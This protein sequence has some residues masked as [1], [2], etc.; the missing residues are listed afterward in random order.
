[1]GGKAVDKAS[2]AYNGKT[3][4]QNVNNLT[5][6]SENLSEWTNPGTWVGWGAPFA[7]RA[8]RT[9]LSAGD[10]I[11]KNA[12]KD[13]AKYG[14]SAVAKNPK[15]WYRPYVDQVKNGWQGW[16]DVNLAYKNNAINENINQ[17]YFK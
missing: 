16:K 6:L 7:S 8:S 9:L 15:G 13:V 1:M 12:A 3:W 14:I 11:V 17:P 4:A 2:Q 5:G 10:Q